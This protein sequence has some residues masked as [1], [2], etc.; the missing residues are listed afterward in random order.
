MPSIL[1][2]TAFCRDDV[3]LLG[4]RSDWLCRLEPMQDRALLLVNDGTVDEGTCN[5]LASLYSRNFKTVHLRT[6]ATSPESNEWP[7]NVNHVWRQVAKMVAGKYGQ[8]INVSTHFAWFYF[9]PDVTPLRPGWIQALEEQY[10]RNK[11]PFLGKV[12]ATNGT[13]KDERTGVVTVEKIYHMNGAGVY[14]IVTDHYNQNMMLCE[15]LPWDVAGLSNYGGGLIKTAD[16][17]ESFY[18]MG[19]GTR[20]YS[21]NGSS[22]SATQTIA[23]S[24]SPY[25]FN[26]T[27]QYLHHGCKDGSL[28]DCL[29]PAKEEVVVATKQVIEP[30]KITIPDRT[31]NDAPKIQFDDKGR[32]IK[33]S[34][35]NKAKKVMDVKKLDKQTVEE[36]KL[37]KEAGLSWKELMAKYKV[38]PAQLS[39]ALKE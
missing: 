21:K 5:D 11:R 4:K 29:M 37:D 15:T 38:T 8:P 32:I 22:F 20:R 23:G 27:S 14:P 33:Q 18:S 1:T 19:F 31:Q 12:N 10:I 35:I 7:K 13:R 30:P 39:K 26:L 16:L 25:T 36:I 28:I 9:E 17:G 2:V 34:N 6:L 24:D 3:G